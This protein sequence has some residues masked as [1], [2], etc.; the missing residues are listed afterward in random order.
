MITFNLVRIIRRIVLQFKKKRYENDIISAL[1]IIGPEKIIF[2]D[3]G[4]RDDI[5]YPWG[6]LEKQGAVKVIGFEPDEAENNLLCQKFI[7]R[8]YYN[9][10]VG[11]FD[12]TQKLLNISINPSQSSVHPPNVDYIKN[13][14][15]EDNWKARSTATQVM[16]DATCLDAIEDDIDFIKIDTQ[17]YE[18]EV[19]KGASKSLIKT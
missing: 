8:K 9:K 11:E 5:P 2:C 16:L 3:V 15:L 6:M 12:G 18:L 10:L 19:L 1:K 13:T 7:D 17:G 4:A 14:Y